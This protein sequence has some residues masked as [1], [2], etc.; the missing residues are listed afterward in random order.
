M[1]QY[2]P[3]LV[4]SFFFFLAGLRV[5]HGAFHHT[6]GLPRWG[7]NFVQLLFSV[8]MLGSMHAVQ[9][10]HLRHHARCLSKDDVESKSA[11]MSGWL[12]LIFGF[13][14]PVLLHWNALRHAKEPTRRWMA[15][16]LWAN[17]LWLWLAI[18]V[19]DDPVVRYHLGAMAAGQCLTAFFAVWTVHRGCHPSDNLARTLR[20]PIVNF[21]TMDMFFHVEHH[22]FPLVPTSQLPKLSARLDHVSPKYREM[23]VL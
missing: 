15:A 4:G 3:A 13:V 20:R 5:V 8:L 23:T 21:L 12:A 14:F 2:I 18:H 16:E 1:E 6:L 19:M 11:R 22:L 9:F 10:S 17:A 7:D